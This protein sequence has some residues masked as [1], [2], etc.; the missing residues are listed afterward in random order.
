MANVTNSKPVNVYRYRPN[1]VFI[2]Y[3][4]ALSFTF[5][6]NLVGAYAYYSNGESHENSYSAILCTTR[7]IHLANLNL[8]ERR[9]VLANLRLALMP[10]SGTN[11]SWSF[12]V[13]Q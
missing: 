4:I 6:A 10:A 12:R 3:G 13:V 2:T 8:H 7:E 5:L 9:W 11:G 1:N